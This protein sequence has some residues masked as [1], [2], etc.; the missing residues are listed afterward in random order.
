M[1]SNRFSES[2][3]IVPI[4]VSTTGDYNAGFTGDSVNMS[5]FNHYTLIIVGDA[6][7]A[8]NGVLTIYG[9]ATDAA[10]TAAA[11]FTYRYS[12]G[13]AGSASSDVLGTAATSAALT[14]TGASLASRM[15][16]C[17]LDAEDLNISGTQYQYVTPVL[18]DA[19]T[20][21]YV[22]MVAILSE[23]RYA[24]AVMDTAVPT[25]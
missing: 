10:T 24:K 16:I 19:G 17:E 9:G 20:G 18:S 8:G 4:A 5:K 7:V 12:S 25:S 6:N 11:T 3:G 21:G 13:D 2:H 14:I 23:P 15:L 22:T 1:A